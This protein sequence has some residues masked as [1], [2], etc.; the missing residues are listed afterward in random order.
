ME[1]LENNISQAQIVRDT[2]TLQNELGD[3]QP[4][5]FARGKWSPAVSLVIGNGI[6]TDQ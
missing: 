3:H 4:D 6:G 2:R 1:K 5:H